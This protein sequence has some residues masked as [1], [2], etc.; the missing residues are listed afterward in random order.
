MSKRNQ[1]TNNF[2]DFHLLGKIVPDQE[3]EE[4]PEKQRKVTT[5]VSKELLETL[6]FWAIDISKDKNQKTTRQFFQKLEHTKSASMILHG[7]QNDLRLCVENIRMP[8]WHFLRLLSG[9]Y[10]DKDDHSTIYDA[11]ENIFQE[12]WIKLN[13]K[14]FW[15]EIFDGYIN[16]AYTKPDMIGRIK[17]FF[18]VLEEQRTLTLFVK[19][20][21]GQE[22]YFVGVRDADH[23][24]YNVISQETFFRHLPKGSRKE[25]EDIYLVCQDFGIKVLFDKSCLRNK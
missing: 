11:V 25:D 19:W 2:R 3:K 23:T 10:V 14:F 13:T 24:W 6:L 9:E 16:L 22:Q 18:A 5:P 15:S 7:D 4:R 20:S 21:S 8:L 1:F 12:K 17:S